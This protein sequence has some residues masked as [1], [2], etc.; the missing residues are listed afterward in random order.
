MLKLSSRENNKTGK[1]LTEGGKLA[2][3][4][5]YEAFCGFYLRF[6][7]F[8]YSGRKREGVP[9]QNLLRQSEC[10]AYIFDKPEA[11]LFTGVLYGGNIR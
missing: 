8:T 10:P 5:V 9:I 2:V 4:G 7:E 6:I 11:R 3:D 1:I